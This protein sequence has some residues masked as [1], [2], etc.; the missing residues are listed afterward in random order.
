MLLQVTETSDY[1]KC[2]RKL[3]IGKIWTKHV[4]LHSET[5]AKQKSYMDMYLKP[6]ST[7]D[8]V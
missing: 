5:N 6:Y 2:S 3:V 7:P 4:L 8:A 1:M